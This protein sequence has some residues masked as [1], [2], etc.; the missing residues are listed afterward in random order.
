MVFDKTINDIIDYTGLKYEYIIK[1]TKEL[2]GVLKPYIQRGDKNSLIFDSNALKIFD[3]VKQLK[4]GKQSITSIKVQLESELNKT[5]KDTQNSTSNLIND[6]Q[7]MQESEL[8]KLLINKLEE[9][10]KKSF[11]SL[12]K[13]LQGKDEVIAVQRRENQELKNQILLITAGKTPE[14]VRAEQH[15]KEQEVF[16]LKQQAEDAKKEAEEIRL[17]E[18]AKEQE[19]LQLKQKTEQVQKESE[20]VKAK[21]AEQTEVLES[22]KLKEEKRQ[23]IIKELKSLEGKWFT[24][25]QRQIL[26]TQLQELS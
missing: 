16:R 9:A 13:V 18:L 25:K 2:D 12:E 24:G 23:E 7:N 20:E 21:V 10:N 6:T 19:L 8:T 11:E 14:E 17:K 26:L 4:E 5:P 22:I 15:I 3:R 1:C